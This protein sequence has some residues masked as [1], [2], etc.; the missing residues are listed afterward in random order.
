MNKLQPKTSKVTKMPPNLQNDRKMLKP[1]KLFI[2]KTFK[3]SNVTE[4]PQKPQK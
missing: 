1:P 3:M 4:T 2:K